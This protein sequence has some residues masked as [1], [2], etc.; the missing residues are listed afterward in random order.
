MRRGVLCESLSV[1]VCG[2]MDSLQFPSSS[3]KDESRLKEGIS[4]VLHRQFFFPLLLA[5][6][7][8]S[9]VR[10]G[11]GETTIS[12][13]ASSTVRLLCIPFYVCD[14]SQQYFT[15][16]LPLASLLLASLRTWLREQWCECMAAWCE[17]IC[18]EWTWQSKR[19]SVIKVC[20]L[21]VS[22][23]SWSLRRRSVA[24]TSS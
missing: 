4:F 1:E 15:S 3:G 2:G 7:G 23:H 14:M 24:D 12:S 21:P 11:R 9:S 22:L 19:L 17:H 5:I 13:T 20:S 6:P 10:R 16:R 18:G 8:V